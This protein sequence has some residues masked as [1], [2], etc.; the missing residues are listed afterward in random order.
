MAAITGTG[1]ASMALFSAIAFSGKSAANTSPDRSALAQK[2]GARTGQH[3]GAH[4]VGGGLL[5]R[6]PG[7]AWSV[8]AEPAL[9]SPGRCN[10]MVVTPPARSIP[11]RP[12]PTDGEPATMAATLAVAPVARCRATCRSSSARLRSGRSA[13]RCTPRFA[14]RYPGCRHSAP[15]LASPDPRPSRPHTGSPFLF[16]RAPSRCQVG[17][18]SGVN[19]E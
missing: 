7:R 9:R 14:R 1:T 16:T 2:T 4:I 11:D 8:E 13:R 10:T 15:Y 12:K 19:C 6:L 17:P 18:A 3:D 5:H